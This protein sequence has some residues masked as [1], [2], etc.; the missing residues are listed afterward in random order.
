[1]RWKSMARITALMPA[2]LVLAAVAQQ[3]G[4]QEDSAAQRAEN[5]KAQ[6]QQQAQKDKP[7]ILVLMP[8]AIYPRGEE[9]ANGCWVRLYE[10]EEFEGRQ[11]TVMGPAELPDVEENVPVFGFESAVV[12]P[13]A[14][15]VTYDGENYEDRTATLEAGRQYADLEDELDLFEDI[16]SLQVSC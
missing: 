15:V 9:I 11:L 5:G 10:G 1:M 7:P 12:G 14:R 2:A 6:T 13:K 16:E 4:A 3:P 8:V